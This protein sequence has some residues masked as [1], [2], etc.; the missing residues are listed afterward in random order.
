VFS[1]ILMPGK[2]NGN[3]LYLWVKAQRPKV[4]VLLTTGLRS[5]EAE[6]LSKDGDS[7]VPIS[8]PK[9]YTK[10]QLA[11]AIGHVSTS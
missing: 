3:D 8:L 1:D 5:E 4:K 7:P 10:A 9:P 6:D 2:I 11:E